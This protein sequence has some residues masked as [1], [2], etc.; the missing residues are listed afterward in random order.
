MGHDELSKFGEGIIEK[1]FS[2]FKSSSDGKNDSAGLSL[3]DFNQFLDAIGSSTIYDNKDYKNFMGLLQLFTDRDSHLMVEGLK[4]YYLKSGRLGDDNSKVGIGS[5]V[6]MLHG[7][8]LLNFN[9]SPDALASMFNL[10]GSNPLLKHK[11]IEFVNM[12]SA[13]KEVKIESDLSMFSQLFELLEMLEVPFAK[14]IHREILGTPGWLA[15]FVNSI[16]EYLADGS[17]GV[18][19]SI[20]NSVLKS[21]G[22]YHDFEK[23]FTLQLN[24]KVTFS[25]EQDE[26]LK[27]L[28]KKLYEVDDEIEE[29]EEQI[30]DL[31]HSFQQRQDEIIQ[32]VTNEFIPKLSNSVEIDHHKNLTQMKE[33]LLFLSEIQYDTSVHLTS[34]QSNDISERKKLLTNLIERT[35]IQ[36]KENGDLLA[37]HS[38]AAY[39]AVR[40]LTDSTPNVGFG[41]VDL[42]VRGLT[43]GFDWV[44]LLPKGAGEYAPLKLQRHE[45]LERAKNRKSAALA[46]LERERC[47]EQIILYSKLKIYSTDFVE[48]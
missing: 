7:N 9:Y 38:C 1:I 2:S 30:R 41:T 27:D 10:V 35:E 8:L 3:W 22:K 44:H 32:A 39:D 5:L 26:T 29:N 15:A 14:V 23:E 34:I 6:E 31:I 46:A 25:L 17:S 19:P 12:L 16:C 24:E 21:F 4:A 48:T 18:I 20:R 33:D 42:C 43:T 11:I 28:E 13:T 36:M 40:L 45:K 47:E 37:A